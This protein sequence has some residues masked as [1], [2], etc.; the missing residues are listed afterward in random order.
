MAGQVRPDGT[1]VL[2]FAWVTKQE[3]KYYLDEQ[4]YVAVESLLSDF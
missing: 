1:N 2:D 4:S 3:M